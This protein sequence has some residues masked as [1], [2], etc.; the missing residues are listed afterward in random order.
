MDPY[1]EESIRKYH[2]FLKSNLSPYRYDHS[3][4]VMNSSVYLAE[5]FGA[6]V[7]AA[8][9]A[10]LLH[11]VTKEFSEAG[12]M[13]LFRESSFYLSEVEL[14]SPKLW[15]AMS[16]SLF[17]TKEFGITDPGIISAIRYHTTGRARMTL[18]DKVIY[19]ADFISDDRTYPDV[20]RVRELS[21]T[22]LEKAMLYTQHYCISHLI[23][24]RRLIHPDSLACY[25]EL[26]VN[27]D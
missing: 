24:G 21:E 20:D 11:D 15:H 13:E 4:G 2:A 12:H 3:L 19:L 23:E 14:K 8:R 9:V 7:D 18:L 25:N 6:D 10:G 16:G 17:V 22:S 5:K 26:L 27:N 1:S